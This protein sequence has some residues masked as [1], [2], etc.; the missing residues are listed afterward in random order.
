[1]QTEILE[2]LDPIEKKGL[3]REGRPG[4]VRRVQRRLDPGRLKP[5]PRETDRYADAAKANEFDSEMIGWGLEGHFSKSRGW[6]FKR[7]EAYEASDFASSIK[8]R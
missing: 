5:I 7:E 1:M 4:L 8:V 2:H 6:A 3:G